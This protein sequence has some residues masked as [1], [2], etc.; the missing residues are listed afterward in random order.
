MNNQ[1]RVLHLNLKKKWYDMWADG[2]KTEDYREVKKHWVSRLCKR[3][4][5]SVVAGGDLRDKHTNTQFTFKKF[6]I[7]QFKN[8]YGKNA[9]TMTFEFLGIDIGEAV[10]EWSDNWKG[11]VFRIKGGKRLT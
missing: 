6:D 1:Q 10:P 9:P 8:G 2:V 7:I 4:S 3:H 11:D 5:Y